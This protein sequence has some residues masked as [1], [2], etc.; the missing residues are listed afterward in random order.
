M[1]VEQM[2]ELAS[3]AALAHLRREEEER[4]ADEEQ[5]RGAYLADAE[6]RAAAAAAAAASG[7]AAGLGSGQD[8]QP[9][10]DGRARP[11]RRGEGGAARQE[12]STMADVG[13]KMPGS[14]QGAPLRKH[15]RQ[16]QGP[17][18]R[19]SPAT[20]AGGKGQVGSDNSGRTCLLAARGILLLRYLLAYPSHSTTLL[21]PS[22][23]SS[24]PPW[25]WL[26]PRRTQPA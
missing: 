1:L 12:T 7:A 14:K 17:G 25:R 8:T 24:L 18:R 2:D 5:A 3:A 11:G 23:A 26:V 6:E 16:A 15:D 4:R 9:Q 21:A 22:C 13:Q 20:N 19:T 10:A